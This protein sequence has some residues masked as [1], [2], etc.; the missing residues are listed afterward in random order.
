VP[1]YEIII[2]DDGSS[3]NTFA[4]VAEFQ[5]RPSVRLYRQPNHGLGATRNRGASLASGD[6][7]YF[8]D[9]D[10]LLDERFVERIQVALTRGPSPD[11]VLFSGRSFAEKP[12]F[13]PYLR[14]YA[15]CATGSGLDS[16]KAINRLLEKRDWIHASACLYVVSRPFWCSSKL[17]YP[18]IVHEDEAVIM[19][20]LFAASSI[21]ILDEVLFYRRFRLDSIMTGVRTF[22]HLHGLKYNLSHAV[23]MIENRPSADPTVK[24]LLRRRCRRMASFYIEQC[25]VLE[26]RIGTWLLMRVAL[27]TRNV[28][29][30]LRSLRAF[31][32]RISCCRILETNRD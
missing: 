24:K 29:L 10:D 21:T 15:R 28:K 23:E 22:A 14:S 11:V 18:E 7:L 17:M 16:V 8:F 32:S 2:I 13:E 1:A 4:V 5:D 27:R 20:L 26:H 19:P 3:D 30:F 25:E 31:F 6:Y 9:A 12:D